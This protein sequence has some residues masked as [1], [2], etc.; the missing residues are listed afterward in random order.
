MLNILIPL[1][2]KSK[3]FEEEQ[4]HS[5]VSLIEINNIPMIEWVIR[6]LNQIEEEKRFLFV[7]RKEDCKKHHLDN[8]LRLLTEDNCEIIQL[9]Q[10]TKGAL[11]SSLLAID[12]INSEDSLI[13]ANGDQYIDEDLN[14][15]IRGFHER[16]LD[17]GALCFESVHPRWSFVRLDE[18]LKVIEASEKVPISRHAM[19]GFYYYRRGQDFVRAAMS[20][21]EKGSSYQGTFFNSAT[22]NE[23]VLLGKNLEITKISKKNYHA[24]FSPQ[25]IQ[26]FQKKSGLGIRSLTEEYVRAFNQ[27][28]LAGLASMFADGITP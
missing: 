26:E 4:Y 21:I 7:V 11:C 17:F 24:F 28:D 3:Y 19:A 20:A 13:I 1:G 12:H 25:R 16:E 2:G 9:G 8:V 6:N 18:N 15:I 14:G 5:P 10:E 23:L 22:I 27:R